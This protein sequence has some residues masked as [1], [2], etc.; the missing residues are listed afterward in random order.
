[1]LAY[2]YIV[3]CWYAVLACGG[4]SGVFFGPGRGRATGCQPSCRHILQE[5]AV[6]TGI[7]KELRFQCE[8]IQ[9]KLFLPVA[10]DGLPLEFSFGVFF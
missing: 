1:V 8:L 6:A 10:V 5:E 2:A 9:I 7:L 4:A 3:P